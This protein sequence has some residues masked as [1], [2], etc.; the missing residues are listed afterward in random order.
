[1]RF[2]NHE[3]NVISLK[4]KSIAGILE[5]WI[6]ISNERN[7]AESMSMVGH[8]LLWQC[9]DQYIKHYLH[10]FHQ[11]SQTSRPHTDWSGPQP[12]AGAAAVCLTNSG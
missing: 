7:N 4:I 1:M 10:Q 9:A 3:K 8:D 11:T 6:L 5:F 12:G 2:C